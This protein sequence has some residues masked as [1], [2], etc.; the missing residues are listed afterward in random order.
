MISQMTSEAVVLLHGLAANRLAMV[1]L[2]RFLAS[3]GF[4]VENWGYRSIRRSI[5][6]HAQE[7]SERLREFDG[8]QHHDRVHIVTHSMGGIIAR[9]A[10]SIDR[11]ANLGRFVMLGPPNSGS[12]V[13][14]RLANTLGRICP[15]LRELSDD[16]E[17]YVNRLGEPNGVDLGIIAAESDRVVKL[18]STFLKNQRDHIVLPGHHGVLPWR[19]DTSEQVVHFLRNGE[20]DWD[21]LKQSSSHR[22]PML[23]TRHRFGTVSPSL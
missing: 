23:A 6:L 7:F 11:P 3:D 13:A 21:A 22:R 12:H 19:R 16:A 14:R 10:L 5:E 18:P 8:S 1:R 4:H 9:R 20:F 15:P 17:S 2:A